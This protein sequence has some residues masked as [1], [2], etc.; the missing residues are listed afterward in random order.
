MDNQAVIRVEGLWKR[1]GLPLMPFLRRG[2]RQA[3]SLV[4]MEPGQ[5]KELPWALQDISFEVRPGETLGLIGRNGSGKSTLLKVLAGVTPPTSGTVMVDGGMFPMI[6]LNAG[7]HMELTGR[8]N[9][10][11]LATVIGLSR[12]QIQKNLPE[13]EAFCELGE[14]L[15]RP[16]RMYSSGMMVRLG[17]AVGV[18]INADILLMD[19]VLAVGDMGFQNK[20]LEH[21]EALRG[22]GK[23]TLFVSHNMQRIRRMC[24]RVL[25]LEKGRPVFMGP[26]E[27]A[28]AAYAKTVGSGTLGNILNRAS[29]DFI[30]TTLEEIGMRVDG[31]VT[32]VMT[33]GSVV[34][35][36]FTLAVEAD[37][38]EATVNIALESP[39]AVSVVW[40]TLDLD[41]QAGR[42]CFEVRWQN[43]RVRAGEYVVRVGVGVG[44]AQRKGFRISKAMRVMMEGNTLYQ[45]IYK[46]E[47]EFVLK[48]RF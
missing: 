33:P 21:L 29:F 31:V 46:P 43:M 40:E 7:V 3:R 34:E 6:E 25:V 24:D 28:I 45:G 2:V 27:D 42:N 19:E 37:V 35:I 14:W 30:G 38:G 18:H 9:I 41:L 1:Y 12:E 20:C 44:G 47:S 32:E 16:V 5:E 4:G 22:R 36:A 10:R 26:P 17:F 11:L 39:D 15:D 48:K 8:E 23:C 13:I